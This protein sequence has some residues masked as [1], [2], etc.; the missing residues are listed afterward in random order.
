MFVWKCL[1]AVIDSVIMVIP[2]SDYLSA[3]ILEFLVVRIVNYFPISFHNM[4]NWKVTFTILLEWRHEQICINDI[5]APNEEIGWTLSIDARNGSKNI[6]TSIL[7]TITRAKCKF[8]NLFLLYLCQKI[9]NYYCGPL[10]I[11]L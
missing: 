6:T 4:V 7:Y 3:L 9:L 8:K 2:D 5:S 1:I 10:R 11:D